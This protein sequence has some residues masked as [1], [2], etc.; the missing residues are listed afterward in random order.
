VD[1]GPTLLKMSETTTVVPTLPSIPNDNKEEDL[2]TDDSDA[3]AAANDNHNEEEDLPTD[4]SDAVAAANDETA[5]SGYD[6]DAVAA[7]NDETDG[8]DYDS[9]ENLVGAVAAAND[10]MKELCKIR[11]LSATSTPWKSKPAKETIQKSKDWDL[12][13][14]DDLAPVHDWLL[15]RDRTTAIDLFPKGTNHVSMQRARN[16]MRLHPFRYRQFVRPSGMFIILLG[17][18]RSFIS[19]FGSFCGLIHICF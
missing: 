5:D 6:S 10:E 17:C 16:D 13:N 19:I 8:S 15:Q 14:G 7:A 11:R 9:D 3:V 1:T 12:L 4:D 2:P 18:H